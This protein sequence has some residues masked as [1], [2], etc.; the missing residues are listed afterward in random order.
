M[1][2]DLLC[3]VLSLLWYFFDDSN[4]FDFILFHVVFSLLTDFFD[5]LSGRLKRS[6]LSVRFISKLG[7]GGD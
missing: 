5:L 1:S 6:R 4:I 7:K 3:P 2:V